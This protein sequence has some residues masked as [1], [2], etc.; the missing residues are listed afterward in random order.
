LKGVV[1]WPLSCVLCD[2]DFL[3]HLPWTV[4]LC[5]MDLD[6]VAVTGVCCCKCFTSVTDDSGV[7]SVVLGCFPI[8][9]VCA[10][11]VKVLGARPCLDWCWAQGKVGYLRV[12]HKYVQVK[13]KSVMCTVSSINS[14]KLYICCIYSGFKMKLMKIW[15]AFF[16]SIFSFLFLI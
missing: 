14:A 6:A 15:L 5:R 4:V 12:P 7:C 10:S 16:C 2:W 9:L 8:S 11:C 3:T 13:T 1:M